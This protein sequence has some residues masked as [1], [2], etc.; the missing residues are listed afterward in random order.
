MAKVKIYGS[1]G[2]GSATGLVG[3]G[4]SANVETTAI[5]STSGV[6]ITPDMCKRNDF[7]YITGTGII[8]LGDDIPVGTLIHLFATGAFLLSTETDA[9]VINNI[10]SKDWTVPAADD[11]L[12]CLK[13]H[14]ANWQVTEETKAGLA[15]QVIPNT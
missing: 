6:T 2:E 9:D 5:S 14:A 15:V 8:K 7:F 13:T 10:A 4:G 11:I 12:H 3:V 1:D